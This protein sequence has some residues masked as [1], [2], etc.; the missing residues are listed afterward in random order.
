[1]IQARWQQ[2]DAGIWE[3]DEDWWTHSRLA[4][5]AGLRQA[6]AVPAFRN[7][8]RLTRLANAILT[9]QAAVAWPPTAPMTHEPRPH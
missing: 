1:V 9:R 6:A 5:D 3:L 4:C 7:G 8:E 2:P